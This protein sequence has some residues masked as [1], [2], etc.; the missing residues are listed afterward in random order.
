MRLKRQKKIVDRLAREVAMFFLK[1][2][3]FWIL[4]RITVT[5]LHDHCSE[6]R[7]VS[8]DLNSATERSRSPLFKNI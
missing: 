1:K 7:R 8:P 6:L 3:G 5:N 4:R 2:S